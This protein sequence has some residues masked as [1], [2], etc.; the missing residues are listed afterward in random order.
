MRSNHIGTLRER[1]LHAAVKDWYA[2]PG[3]HLEI[4]VDGYVIDLIRGELLIEIQTRGFSPLKQKLERLTQQHSVRLVHPIG[5]EKWIVRV[6]A[7]GETLI[8]RRKSPKRGRPEDVFDH[9]VSF[10]ELITRDTFVLEVLMIQEE[11]VRCHDGNG[12]WRHPEWQRADRRLLGVVEQRRLG[13]PDD[14]RAFL[15]EDLAR[16]FTNRDLMQ[17]ADLPLRLTG[18]VTY[19]LRRMGVLEVVGKRGNAQLF[20]DALTRR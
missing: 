12:T 15:P 6:E 14:F 11:E 19:C 18:K 13:T 5:H 8:G 4:S 2:R 7:D 20:A 9:L 3:D 1:S 17:A 16:P 10:P